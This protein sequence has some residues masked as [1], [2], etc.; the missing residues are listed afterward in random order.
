MITWHWIKISR[1]K[2]PYHSRLS[3]KW[4]IPSSTSWKYFLPLHTPPVEYCGTADFTCMFLP[5][6]TVFHL[7]VFTVFLNR[8]YRISDIH[9]SPVFIVS[10]PTYLNLQFF[11][12]SSF[13]A[14]PDIL[15]LKLNIQKFKQYSYRLYMIG[16]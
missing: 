11:H 12:K 7:H 14:V 15:F 16:Q 13:S 9:T 1:V 6:F 10:L 4:K 2:F 8:V 5:Y 3:V